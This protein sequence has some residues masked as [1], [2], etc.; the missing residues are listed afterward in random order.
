MIEFLLQ[1]MDIKQL[2][3]WYKTAIIAAYIV[4]GYLNMWSL[5]IRVTNK[6]AD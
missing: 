5:D 2:H 4:S 6:M 3:T 1:A